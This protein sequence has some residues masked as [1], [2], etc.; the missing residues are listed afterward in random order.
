MKR[1][2]LFFS[3]IQVPVDYAMILIA[4][5]TAFLIR[6]IPQIIALKP[7]LYDFPFED[8][9]QLV[10]IVA[11]FFLLIYALEGLYDIRVT[12]KFWKEA[13]KVFFATS[14]GLVIIIVII[15]IFLW[16]HETRVENYQHACTCKL[17]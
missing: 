13:L 10:A 11:P 17:C 16:P 4:G 9:I 8:Y 7:K 2:E 3:A 1:S 12:R 14:I 6:D 15:F 5:I